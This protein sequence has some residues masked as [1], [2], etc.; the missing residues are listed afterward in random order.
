MANEKLK[1]GIDGF[2]KAL[3]TLEDLLKSR[4]AVL[5]G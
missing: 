1:E 4:L 3:E 5:E 2:T